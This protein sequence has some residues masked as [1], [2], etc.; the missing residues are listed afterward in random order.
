MHMKWNVYGILQTQIS[1]HMSISQTSI[2]S[3]NQINSYEMHLNLGHKLFLW[4]S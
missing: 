3:S 1:E 4:H 2:I